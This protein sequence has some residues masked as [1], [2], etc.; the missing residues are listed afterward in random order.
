MSEAER[1]AILKTALLLVIMAGWTP[2]VNV[3]ARLGIDVRHALLWLE[4]NGYVRVTDDR[5]PLARWRIQHS[6]EDLWRLLV[7]E[8]AC[9]MRLCGQ[10]SGTPARQL[11]Q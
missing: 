11:R 6:F 7:P 9:P 10:A 4:Q 1:R 3:R 8:R 2:V 5:S